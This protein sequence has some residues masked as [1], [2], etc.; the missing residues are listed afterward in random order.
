MYVV[1]CIED[2]RFCLVHDKHVICDHKTVQVGDIVAFYYNDI[3]YNGEVYNI[4]D[5]ENEMYDHYRSHSFVQQA[6]K[7]EATNPSKK[8][9]PP[10]KGHNRG[11]KKTKKSHNPKKTQLQILR[12]Q[13]EAVA[14]AEKSINKM[15]ATLTTSRSSTPQID[16]SEDCND[17]IFSQFSHELSPLE[18]T[19]ISEIDANNLSNCIKTTTAQDIA[20]DIEYAKDESTGDSKKLQ[21][22]YCLRQRHPKKAAD[23]ARQINIAENPNRSFDSNPSISGNSDSDSGDEDFGNRLIVKM[24]LPSG[25]RRPSEDQL[26]GKNYPHAKMEHI[27]D[28]IWCKAEILDA[29]EYHSPSPRICAK[30]M[31]TGTFREYAVYHG[32][33]SKT[34]RSAPPKTN[35]NPAIKPHR[36]VLHG[37]AVNAIIGIFLDLIVGMQQ[38]CRDVR[39]AK[40]KAAK[41]GVEYVY[42]YDV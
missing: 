14:E 1:Q 41:L 28:N 42:G 12:K 16:I 5:D 26:F 40:D 38:F 9:R 19:K 15:M 10:Q 23:S 39:K 21:G 36:E 3:K 8:R 31:M 4:G 22:R 25:P 35:A 24:S 27:A 17:D 13:E 2:K 34:R 37:R 18:Q 33:W 6:I 20:G 29:A 7:V 32:V 30:R 11:G